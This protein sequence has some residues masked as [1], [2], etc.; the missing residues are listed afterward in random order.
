MKHFILV[1][2][3]GLFALIAN[4]TP[5]YNTSPPGA[6][7]LMTEGA[8]NVFAQP[9]FD[10]Q[11]AEVI[12]MGGLVLTHSAYKPD[13]RTTVRLCTYPVNA[14]ERYSTAMK[15]SLSDGEA[16]NTLQVPRIKSFY[17]FGVH[18]ACT[19]RASYKVNRTRGYL[20]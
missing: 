7:I 8:V 11:Q 4:A 20:I 17:V 10:I 15:L 12:P 16:V 6:S 13:I 2:F 3:F 14:S 5:V 18:R 19:I 1:M 9:S